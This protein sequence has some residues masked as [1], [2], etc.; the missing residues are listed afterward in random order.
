MA[1][2]QTIT[3]INVDS[4]ADNGKYPKY[5]SSTGK[6]TMDTPSGGGGS[7]TTR[8]Q[9]TSS[10][11]SY[12]SGNRWENNNTGSGSGTAFSG[13]GGLDFKPGTSNG[14]EGNILLDALGGG[15]S[16]YGLDYDD[17]FECQWFI[18]GGA[19]PGSQEST[20]Y[21]TSALG[22]PGANN[23]A[24]TTTHIGFYM[25]VASGA[26][27]AFNASCAMSGSQTKTDVKA[28]VTWTNATWYRAIMNS[29]TN[30][31]Y[32]VD[33]TLVATH[34]TNIP[35]GAFGSFINSIGVKNDAG[36]SSNWNPTMTVGQVNLLWD[37]Q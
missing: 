29:G 14:G 27:N 26:I 37:A 28:S 1:N 31:K 9:M 4:A 21:F 20:V 24:F 23:G 6:F 35:S 34:T 17:N 25:D 12:T 16:V 22:T 8:V 33:K 11:E 10:F 19:I 13:L 32:Y 30:V 3:Q 36:T 7:S 2:N 15:G 18:R 5:N